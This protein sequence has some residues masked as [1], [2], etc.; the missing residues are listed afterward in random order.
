MP[1]KA[2]SEA[3][4]NF[5]D[6][7]ALAFSFPGQRHHTESARPAPPKRAL[8]TLMAVGD[9]FPRELLG[10]LGSNHGEHAFHA[11][12]QCAELPLVLA[13]NVQRRFHVLQNYPEFTFGHDALGTSFPPPQITN[14]APGDWLPGDHLAGTTMKFKNERCLSVAGKRN[15]GRSGQC[16]LIPV[17]IILVTSHR[18]ELPIQFRALPRSEHRP[19]EQEKLGERFNAI[20]DRLHHSLRPRDLVVDVGP[21]S[22]NLPEDNSRAVR[23][24]RTTGNQ[25][26][27]DFFGQLQKMKGR[28]ESPDNLEEGGQL[29]HLVEASERSGNVV[30]GTM[31]RVTQQLTRTRAIRGEKWYRTHSECSL[32]KK[33]ISKRRRVRS[34]RPLPGRRRLPESDHSTAAPAALAPEYSEFA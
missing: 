26:R 27:N 19:V 9:I 13:I 1:P 2:A 33:F 15:I 12:L 32:R 17:A 16:R 6:T 20:A 10:C 21:K 29:G 22:G 25:C 23:R 18:L 30:K 31:S 3:V 28:R 24:G 11:D 8:L 5:E 7:T 4:L 34:R 14:S